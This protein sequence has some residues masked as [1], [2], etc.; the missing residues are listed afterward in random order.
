MIEK[1]E[2]MLSAK[3]GEIGVRS[4]EFL[5]MNFENGQYYPRPHIAEELL[6]F[7]EENLTTKQIQQL[8]G[9]AN[10]L[11]DIISHVSNHTSQLSKLLKKHPPVWGTDYTLAVQILKR[12]AQHPPPL[13]I[14]DKGLRT[15]IK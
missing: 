6:K 9:I 11:R 2:I 10:Y 12:I 13:K 15:T 3:K 4:I 8:L 7:A 5:K 14:L 1:Y